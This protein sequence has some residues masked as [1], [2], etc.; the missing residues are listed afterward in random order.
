M[1][2]LFEF[3]EAAAQHFDIQIF[4]SRTGQPGGVEAM[5]TWFVYERHLWRE[6]GGMH[7]RLA[8]LPISFPMHKPPAFVTI[9]D[10]GFR[11]EGTWPDPEALLA[12]KPWWK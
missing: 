11:F 12:L 10:R 5:I 3:L 4:S 8:A 1:P 7:K 9:D 2:G 6:E